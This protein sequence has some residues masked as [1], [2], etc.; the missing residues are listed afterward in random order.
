MIKAFG[1][2]FLKQA[3]LWELECAVEQPDPEV[4]HSKRAA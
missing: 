3:R 2:S 4:E 1:D